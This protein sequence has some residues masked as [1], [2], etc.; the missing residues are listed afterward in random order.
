MLRCR[1]KLRFAVIAFLLICMLSGTAHGVD[2][3]SKKQINEQLEY[4]IAVVR[5]GATSNIRNDAAKH[6]ADL[7]REIA[8]NEIDDKIIADIVS[9]L[10]LPVGRIWVASSLANIGPPAKMAIPKLQELIIMEDCHP[11]AGLSASFAIR[12]ALERMGVTPPPF[13]VACPNP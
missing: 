7:T 13:P 4:T 2:K 5:T 3:M 1:S 8:P 9:L 6:L 12:R 11:L 10:D